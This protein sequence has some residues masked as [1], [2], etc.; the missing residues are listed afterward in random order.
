M[1]N[2]YNLACHEDMYWLC[3]SLYAKRSGA[4]QSIK[5]PDT[6]GNYSL[7]VYKLTW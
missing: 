4:N 7:K 5:G 3:K 6:I 1:T 2:V